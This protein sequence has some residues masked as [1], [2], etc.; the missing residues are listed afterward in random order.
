ML[1][2]RLIPVLYLKNGYLVRSERFSQYNNLGNPLA[3]VE[4]YSSW[5]VDEL[6][7]IDIAP[8][9]APSHRDLSLASSHGSRLLSFPDVVATVA[10]AASMPLTVGGGI[11]TVKDV[12][13]LFDAGADKISINFQAMKDVRF[14]TEVANRYGSQAVVV[15]IDVKKTA[16]KRWSVEDK[17]GLWKS[18]VAP[19]DWADDLMQSGA[20]EILLTS[21]DRDGTGEGYDIEIIRRVSRAVNIPVIALGGVGNYRDFVDGIVEGE[22]SAVAAGNIFHFKELAYP[23]AKRELKHAGLNFR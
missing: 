17:F 21:T 5:D 7:Y 6:I 12:M 8:S 9:E 23:V 10:E 19:E 11:R 14:V 2:N 3:Q 4:R 15:S 20:G 16:E 13:R 1:K 18:R 22:A